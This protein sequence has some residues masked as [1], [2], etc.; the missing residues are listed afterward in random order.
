M[1]GTAAEPLKFLD[2]PL[3]RAWELNPNGGNM[4]GDAQFQLRAG[5]AARQAA[6]LVD[7]SRWFCRRFARVEAAREAKSQIEQKFGQTQ[8]AEHHIQ[9]FNDWLEKLPA[10][11][12]ASLAA[13]THIEHFLSSLSPLVPPDLEDSYD[14]PR[15]TLTDEHAA[16]EPGCWLCISDSD[17]GQIAGDR[18]TCG[19]R[20]EESGPR[21]ALDRLRWPQAQQVRHDQGWQEEADGCSGDGRHS[22]D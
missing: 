20:C 9:S 19:S 22:S 12:A 14:P 11:L 18:E 8:A 10:E 17:P 13:T 2:V 21:P 6:T 3:R 4:A 15:K 5:G 7:F 1:V 16:A